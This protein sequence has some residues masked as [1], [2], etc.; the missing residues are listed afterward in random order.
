[1]INTFLAVPST[2]RRLETGAGP[3]AG[4]TVELVD[5]TGTGLA[6]QIEQSPNNY[7]TF[8]CSCFYIVYYLYYIECGIIMSFRHISLGDI[9]FHFLCLCT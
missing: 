1:M 6:A 9:I 5:M 4:D 7:R 3:G 2:G 8:Y